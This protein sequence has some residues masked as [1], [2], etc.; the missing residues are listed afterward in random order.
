MTAASNRK[1]HL[2]FASELNGGD[3]TSH[4]RA[5]RNQ[6]GT[7]V[8][9]GIVDLACVIIARIVWLDQ[10]TTKDRLDCCYNCVAWY[11]VLLSL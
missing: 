10:L 2:V 3:N 8:D 1:K 7:S 5:T 4:I 9:R 11:I 6:G